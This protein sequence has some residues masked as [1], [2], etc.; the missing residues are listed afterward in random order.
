MTAPV[1]VLGSLNAD[2]VVRVERR[3]RGGETVLGSDLAVNPGGKGANQAVAAAR[4]GGDVAMVGC[5][6]HDSY[7]ALLLDSLRSSGVDA[8]GVTVASARATGVALITVTPDGENSIVV[9]PGANGLVTP[10]RVDELD[11]ESAAIALAQLELPVQA[12]SRLAECAGAAGVRFVLNHAPIVDLPW[13]AVAVA[14]PLV[15]NE[16]ELAALAGMPG[17]SVTGVGQAA[18]AARTLVRRGCTSV[19]V[20]L[21]GSG[22]GVLDTGGWVHVPAPSVPV[23]DTTAA[24]DAFVGALVV[25]LAA[26]R[27]LEEATRF[28][29]RAGSLA[30]Q[31]VGAQGSLP[32]REEVEGAGLQSAG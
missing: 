10:E 21:G 4:L 17:G 11:L 9:A 22:A 7:G 14:D 28:A 25:E 23:V 3:P 2:L 31:R 32:T 19:V 1:L 29:V 12:V 5:V 6:G 8:K 18:Q 30:V 13:E 26:G 27:G 20:T 16:H 24:G 15:V